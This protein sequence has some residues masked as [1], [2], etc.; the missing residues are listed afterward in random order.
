[1]EMADAWLLQEFHFRSRR[2]K[3]AFEG[4]AAILSGCAQLKKLNTHLGISFED[5]DLSG[6]ELAE[7]FAALCPNLTTFYTSFKSPGM[8]Y[9]IPSGYQPSMDAFSNW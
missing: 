8:G 1:M 7:V 6:V 3:V 4:V 9:N 2:E 5:D